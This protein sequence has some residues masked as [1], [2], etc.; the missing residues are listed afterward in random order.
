MSFR[1]SDEAVSL[2]TDRRDLPSRWFASHE[3]GTSLHALRGG[4]ELLLS[5]RGAG[6]SA[7]QLEAMSLIAAATGSIERSVLLLGELAMLADEPPAV[8]EEV[9]LSALLKAP[10]ISSFL[11]PDARLLE[12]G[13]DLPVR[14]APGLVHRAIGHLA[15]AG[16]AGRPGHPIAC[17]LRAVSPDTVSI[18]L[19]VG[20]PASGEGAI[21]L[22]LATALLEAAGAVFRSAGVAE[23]GA[24]LCLPRS[25]AEC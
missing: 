5:E 13:R 23:T 18:G 4:V 6:L 10:A 7:L 15:R 25:C 14:L 16:V 8:P 21:A 17:D 19:A 22:R 9:G 2:S 11:A 24:I 3:L 1:E 12:A 20:F